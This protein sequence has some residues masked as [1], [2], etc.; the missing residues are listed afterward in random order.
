M[1]DV[2]IAD[3]TQLA[4]SRNSAADL[5]VKA[6][7]DATTFLMQQGGEKMFP[8]LVSRAGY[9]RRQLVALTKQLADLDGFI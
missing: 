5:I 1:S 6:V 4:K 9:K 3:E 7:A 2:H 8:S